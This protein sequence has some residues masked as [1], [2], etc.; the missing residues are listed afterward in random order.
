MEHSADAVSAVTRW[1]LTAKAMA[2][3]TAPTT[4]KMPRNSSDVTPASRRAHRR[5]WSR[6]GSPHHRGRGAG[7]RARARGPSPGSSQHPH[8]AHDLGDA[9]GPEPVRRGEADDVTML[10]A[11]PARDKPPAPRGAARRHAS[12]R[13]TARAPP[14]GRGP[15]RAPR[16]AHRPEVVLAQPLLEAALCSRQRAGRRGLDD[17]G[18]RDPW[19]AVGRR[20]A[21]PG[22]L[23]G[24]QDAP[25]F[26]PLARHGHRPP[27]PRHLPAADRAR[28]D[29]GDAD[30]RRRGG[31]DVGAGERLVRRAARHRDADQAPPRARPPARP[32]H[33]VDRSAATLLLTPGTS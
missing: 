23:T 4:R 16:G 29:G 22:H 32:R 7:R 18:H 15:A 31:A 5:R 10:D 12:S 30:G 24:R 33:R 20:L 2:P 3:T 17:H 21:P 26:L 27:P 28:G 1:P 14:V 11:G 13:S 25:P 9:R 8:G 6:E 19:P